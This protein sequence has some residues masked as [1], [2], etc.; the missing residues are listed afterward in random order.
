MPRLKKAT[1]GRTEKQR[2][3]TSASIAIFIGVLAGLFLLAYVG[4]GGKAL[5]LFL[6]FGFLLHE[7]ERPVEHQLWIHAGKSVVPYENGKEMGPMEILWVIFFGAAG[8]YVVTGI[9]AKW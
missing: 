8:L 2:L 6:V 7:Y 5:F 4:H 3:S 1:T 9:V